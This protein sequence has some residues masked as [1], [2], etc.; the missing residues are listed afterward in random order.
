MSLLE[1]DVRLERRTRGGE[2]FRL[3]AAFRSEGGVTVVCGPSG[4]G[5]STLLLAMLGALGGA[6]GRVRLGDTTLLDSERD[7]DLPVAL[8]SNSRRRPSIW[9]W[10]NP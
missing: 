2:T 8:H 5:K 6:Q 9:P 1:V 3:D 10:I 4:A 7:I